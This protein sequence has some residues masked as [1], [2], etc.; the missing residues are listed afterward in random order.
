[1][2]SAKEPLQS[3]PR[4]LRLEQMC[5]W[6]VRQG[7]QFMQGMCVSALTKS[8]GLTRRQALPDLDHRAGELVPH[9]L[10]DARADPA[11]RPLVPLVDVDVGAADRRGRDLDQRLVR[12]DDRDR[13]LP[14]LRPFARGRLDDRP[15]L[16][17][18]TPPPASDAASRPHQS[19]VSPRFEPTGGSIGTGPPR[20][21]GAGKTGPARAGAGSWRGEPSGL[22]RAVA[23][24]TRLVESRNLW[25]FLLGRRTL[26]GFSLASTALA[27]ATAPEGD[28]PALYKPP[29]DD[30]VAGQ[31]PR[32]RS[33]PMKLTLVALILLVLAAAF[34]APASGLTLG[35]F[36][37]FEDGTTQ[38]WTVGLL[39][40]PHPA[41]P[42]N[43]A[44]GGPDGAGD[45]FLQLTSIGGGGPGSRL[46]ALNLGQWAGDYIASGVQ[47]LGMDLRNQ[48]STDL[49]L[50]LL[51]S[52]PV[53]GPPGNAAFS[54]DAISLSAGGDWTR[55]YFAVDPS[56][57]TALVGNAHDAF[58]GATELRIFHSASASYPPEPIA[59]LLGVDNITALAAVPAVPEPSTW[60]LFA[61]SVGMLALLRRRR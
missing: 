7:T 24:R 42:A 3:T 44:D 22:E 18:H 20:G 35:Q 17:R 39:G 40:A 45:N 54:T 58:S 25:S 50:R 33:R 57:F 23:G 27:Q 52:D 32:V 2:Y 21:Q 9:R 12:S 59:A 49:A 10:R 5:I 51:L 34:V 6:P 38:N 14:Q 43:I 13:H 41:P 16:L 61:A 55:V 56:V 19:S 11:L 4:I 48:G 46:T 28:R 1:M 30:S 29:A 26:S 47:Y 37:D 31:E 53:A 36:D 8:P 60:S 15:H